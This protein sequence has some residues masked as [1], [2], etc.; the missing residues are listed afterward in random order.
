MSD[1]EEFKKYCIRQ[2]DKNYS[3]F[4]GYRELNPEIFFELEVL[5]NENM[6]CL[7]FNAHTASITMSNH[8]LERLLKLALIYHDSEGKDDEVALK[9]HSDYDSQPLA[10]NII[11]CFEKGLISERGKQFLM[12]NVKNI[13]RNGFSHAETDKILDGF[14]E[15]VPL[16]EGD[17]SKPGELKSITKNRKILTTL[18]HIQMQSFAEQIAIQ[19]YKYVFKLIL[20]I[21]SQILN[22]S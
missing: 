17:F 22:K 3:S 12:Q 15:D 21:E 2:V 9:A 20:K 4:E 18:S 14:P 7:M 6:R 10:K 5:M 8:I 1:I 11:S 16:L 19:Y 13:M